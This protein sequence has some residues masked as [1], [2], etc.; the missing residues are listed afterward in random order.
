LIIVIITHEKLYSIFRKEFL[1]FTIK[2]RGKGLIMGYYECWSLEAF[3]YIGNSEGLARASNTKEN[4]V[5]VT[6]FNPSDKLFNCLRLITCG[7]KI[8]YKAEALH[9]YYFATNCYF[10]IDGQ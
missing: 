2:L 5:P 1:E 8:T 4:L 9:S 6:F 7:F 3:N 10:V